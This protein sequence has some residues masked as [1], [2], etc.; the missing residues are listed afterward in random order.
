MVARFNGFPKETLVFLREL[1][2]NNNRE[3]FHEN[4]SRYEQSVVTP[5]MDFIEAMGNFLPQL[6]DSFIA[7]TRR[8][9]GS[10]F[11]IY[12]D[13]RFA[14]D[15]RPYK[16]NVGCQFRHTA[17]KSAH[18][19]GF[20]LHISP[21]EVFVGGGVWCPDNTALGMIRDAIVD[22]S[23]SWAKVVEDPVMNKHF[24]GLQGESLKRPPRGYDPQ[25]PYIEDLK[26][27]SYMTFRHF[28]PKAIHRADFIDEV[29]SSFEKLMPLM[30]FICHGL[31]LPC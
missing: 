19:P 31:H 17:G 3:W 10:M 16:E 7:D 6:S 20:Y 11:R 12:R 26:R 18:A 9:G 30:R 28:S 15:K 14:K 13:T 5:V 24:G 1:S 29:E 2:Q 25:H 23:Q 27:K 22:S 4:K 8:N 21:E